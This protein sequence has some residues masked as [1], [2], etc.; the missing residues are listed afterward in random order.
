MSNLIDWVGEASEAWASAM[1]SMLSV[2]APWASAALQHATE[3]PTLAVTPRD[4]VHCDGT[5]KLYHFRRPEGVEAAPRRPVLIVPSMINTWYVMDLR[6]GASVVEAL[7]RSGL[8]VW[9]LDWGVARDEDRYLSW[10]EV[11]ARLARA[12]RVIRRETSVESLGLLGYCMGATLSGIYA[13]LYPDKVAALINLAGPF[14]FSKGGVL[15]E[16]TDPRWFD[17]EG[18]TAL[19]NLPPSQMQA[20]FVALRPTSQWAKWVG[21]LDRRSIP[22]A[23]ASFQALEAWANDNIPF[24]GSSY[25]TYIQDL[26]Q[27]NLLV[28]GEHRVGGRRV[29]L[30]AIQCPL[31]TIGA[32]RD[33]ICPVPAAM[34]LHDH[35]SSTDKTL[36]V[37]SGGHVGAV[38]GSKASKV[39]YPLMARW[40]RAR[41][42]AD[43]LPA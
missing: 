40:L 38:V 18:V 4:V 11:V 17:A 43:A 20:G 13:A 14:D 30:S 36:E 15:K 1:P 22:G 16:L 32:D 29:D 2:V 41:L 12:A 9:C 34:G 31:L 24:P 19:G 21:Y 42:D 10:E 6:P 37:V 33:A 27:E 5:A 39:L 7:V 28:R 26:Y 23:R 8:D 25:V 35:V 3:R